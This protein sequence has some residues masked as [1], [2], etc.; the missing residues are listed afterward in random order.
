MRNIYQSLKQG[1]NFFL[2]SS[3]PFIILLTIFL[4]DLIAFSGVGL[5]PSLSMIFA[6][7]PISQVGLLLKIPNKWTR[8]LELY[9]V[10]VC[11][12]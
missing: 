6:N 8:K 1:K 4:S 7:A 11:F 3:F 2:Y 10:E 5:L 9:I 12:Y